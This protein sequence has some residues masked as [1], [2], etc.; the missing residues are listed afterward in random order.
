MYYSLL[1]LDEGRWG[2]EFGDHDREVVKEEREDRIFDMTGPAWELY[3]IARHRNARQAT[4]DKDVAKINKDHV[5]ALKI[6]AERTT[7]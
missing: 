2:V 7:T 3:R 1:F 6:M 5:A 4:I